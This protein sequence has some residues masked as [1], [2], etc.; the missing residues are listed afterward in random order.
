M[1][2][3]QKVVGEYRAR[4]RARA[5][6]LAQPGLTPLFPSTPGE[7]LNTVCLNRVSQAV[8]LSELC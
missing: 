2:G 4:A 8:V 6:A 1:A 5:R 3:T 7:G